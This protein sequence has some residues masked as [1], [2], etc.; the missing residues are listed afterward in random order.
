[1][2]I[3]RMHSPKTKNEG[4]TLIELVVALLVFTVGIVGIL[5]MHQASVQA[6]SYNMQLTEAVAVAQNQLETLHGLAFTSTSMAVGVHGTNII[7]SPRNFPYN[8][9]WLVTN[10]GSVFP[11]RT[12]ALSVTWQE[13]NIPHEVDMNVIWDELY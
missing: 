13:R 6:N 3:K 7:P 9:S 8:V 5:K 11:T 2:K 4:F 1:M 10:P 12:I